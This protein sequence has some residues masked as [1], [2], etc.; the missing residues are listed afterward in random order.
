MDWSPLRSREGAHAIA[1]PELSDLTVDGGGN[2]NR[3][4]R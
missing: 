4:R 2:Q 1:D 3:E